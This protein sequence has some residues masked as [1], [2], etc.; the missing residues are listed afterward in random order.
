M[1]TQVR[2]STPRLRPVACIG[3]EW[4]KICA[5]VTASRAVRQYLA[6]LDDAAFRAASEVTPGLSLNAQDR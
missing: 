6:T 5:G 1:R 2:S 4:K 3:T